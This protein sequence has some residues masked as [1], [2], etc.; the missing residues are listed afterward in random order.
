MGD[1]G[2][3]EH[4]VVLNLHVLPLEVELRRML[5]NPRNRVIPALVL[6]H[7]RLYKVAL[8]AGPDH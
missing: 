4:W 8:Q 7:Q 1:I 3:L 5:N 6:V 2:R